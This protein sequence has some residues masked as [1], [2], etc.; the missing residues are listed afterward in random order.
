[1]MNEIRA[2]NQ[3]EAKQ[4]VSGI[5][6]EFENLDANLDELA[7]SIAELR[8]C[9]SLLLRPSEP[10]SESEGRKLDSPHL[11]PLAS[12]VRDRSARI[13]QVIDALKDIRNRIDL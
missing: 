2:I 13:L 1:M 5:N 4:R 8:D 11:S 7:K 10:A 9:L 6:T 12:A 3:A